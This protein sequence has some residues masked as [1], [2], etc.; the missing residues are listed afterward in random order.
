MV[1]FERFVHLVRAFYAFKNTVDDYFSAIVRE[2]V[3]GFWLSDKK[4]RKARL[5]YGRI[6]KQLSFKEFR[7]QF[8]LHLN[9][10]ILNKFII[11]KIIY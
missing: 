11:I 8:L 9:K 4:A 10:F 2:I 1:S 6:G 3:R 5:P 7:K